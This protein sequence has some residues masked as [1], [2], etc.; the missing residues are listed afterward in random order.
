MKKLR[1]SHVPLILL[2]SAS[3]VKRDIETLNMQFQIHGVYSS[4]LDVPVNH[5]LLEK[6]R[7]AKLV[8][9]YY[10]NPVKTCGKKTIQLL[11]KNIFVMK[12]GV[13]RTQ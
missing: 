10:Q 1:K 5:Y 13:F 7:Q 12:R 4:Y 8:M 9:E 3:H 2:K 11:R 6:E